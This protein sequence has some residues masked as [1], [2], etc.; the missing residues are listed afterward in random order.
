MLRLPSITIVMP[1]HTSLSKAPMF[2]SP[3]VGAPL[4]E[5]FAARAG[6]SNAANPAI[7]VTPVSHTTIRLGAF[8]FRA[9]A[10]DIGLPP[11]PNLSRE[12]GLRGTSPDC[13][14]YT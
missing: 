14:I 10:N 9:R 11:R 5:Q 2:Q 4:R 6:P 1:V 7:S 13:D 3:G 8:C 12:T